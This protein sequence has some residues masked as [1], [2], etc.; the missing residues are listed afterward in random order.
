VSPLMGKLLL[1]LA[2]ALRLSRMLMRCLR[3]GLCVAGVLLGFCKI[4]LGMLLGGGPMRLGCLIV[5]IGRLLVHILWHEAAPLGL[6]LV[7][8]YVRSPA[9]DSYRDVRTAGV[10]RCP[11]CCSRCCCGQSFFSSCVR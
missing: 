1:L 5:L 8:K 9:A 7:W 10:R 11:T 2:F 3:F 4:A 6:G